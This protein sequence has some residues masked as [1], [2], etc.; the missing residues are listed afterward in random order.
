MFFFCLEIK[1]AKKKKIHSLQ[2]SSNLKGISV[3]CITLSTYAAKQTSSANNTS[4]FTRSRVLFAFLHLLTLIQ[5]KK[6]TK[7]KLYISHSFTVTRSQLIFK[8]RVFHFHIFLIF[9]AL[10][11]LCTLELFIFSFLLLTF[12]I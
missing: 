3:H 1:R 2:H 10:I 12:Q 7:K 8:T 5:K 6:K 9:I 11:P 4:S